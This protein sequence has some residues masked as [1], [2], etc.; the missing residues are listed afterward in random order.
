ML[1]CLSCH[2]ISSA[3][4]YS[5]IGRP[6]ALSYDRLLCTVLHH[7]KDQSSL[8]LWAYPILA[9]EIDRLIDNEIFFRQEVYRQG[10]KKTISVLPKNDFEC[11]CES[12]SEVIQL[13]YMHAQS[14]L[15]LSNV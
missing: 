12:V 6:S 2:I 4:R 15:L 14:V 11:L 8:P 1:F 5:E 7:L 13:L 9:Q 3:K 10:V